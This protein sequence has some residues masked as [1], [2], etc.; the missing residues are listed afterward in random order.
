MLCM[1]MEAY[2]L[3]KALDFPNRYTLQILNDKRIKV[4]H[5]YSLI[6]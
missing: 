4:L 6:F 3:T 5:D 1:G 2:I